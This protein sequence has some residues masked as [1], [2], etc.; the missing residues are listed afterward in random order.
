[1]STGDLGM[2]P[3]RNRL[4]PPPWSAKV[5]AIERM[6][7]VLVRALGVERHEFADV[8]AGDVGRDGVKGAAVFG[9]GVRLHVVHVEVRRAAREPDEDHR[10]VEPRV[11]TAAD[12]RLGFEGA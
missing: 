12:A 6:I 11:E 3:V 10:G 9:R 8:E 4:C 7:S 5:W 2:R 1:M